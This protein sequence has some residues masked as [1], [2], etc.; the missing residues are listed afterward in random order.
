MT[1]ILTA[2]V[3]AFQND[4]VLLVRHGEGAGHLTGVYGIPGGRLQEGEES[5]TAAARELQ[6]ETGL[7]VETSDLHEFAN[8]QFTADIQRKDGE[9]KRY[10]MT[11]FYAETFSGELKESE[12][13]TPEWIT[14]ADLQT[15]NLLPNVQQAIENAVQYRNSL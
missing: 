7:I 9:V 14:I 15:Y 12:E 13:T 11:V 8:N 2:H 10:T 6:E 5:K 1:P 4:N 3:L